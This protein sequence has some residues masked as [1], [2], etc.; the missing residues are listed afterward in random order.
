VPAL[1]I[2]TGSNGAGKSTV[3]PRYLPAAIRENYSVFDGDKL[4]MEKQ[5]ELFPYVTKS[6]KE[7]KKLAKAFVTSTFHALVEDALSKGDNFVYEGHFTND[8]TWLVPCQFKDAEYQIH[9]YLLGLN[10][11]DLSQ[12]RVTDRVANSRG[13]Y[14]DRTT[15][16]ANFEGNLEKVNKYRSIIDFLTIIDSSEIDHEIIATICGGVVDSSITR[17]ELPWWIEKYMPDIFALIL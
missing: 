4:Y 13:H 16:E 9:L 15:I 1:Y 8:N 5:A 10:D 3:G 11:H 6:P 17:S 7:S 14:V 12:A 2:I